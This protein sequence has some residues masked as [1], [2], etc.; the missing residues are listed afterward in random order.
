MKASIPEVK[1]DKLIRSYE[2]LALDAFGVLVDE[3]GAKEGAAR[4]IDHLNRSGKPYWIVTNGS[5]REPAQMAIYYQSLGL[6][7]PASRVITSGCLLMDYF[8]EESLKGAR[9]ACLG[10]TGSMKMVENAGGVVIDP[11]KNDDFD[12]LVISNQTEFPFLETIDAVISSVIK[13]R[14]RGKVVRLVLTNP[15]LI[16]PKG[17]ESFGITSGAIAILVER[18]LDVRF[19]GAKENLFTRLGKPYAPIFRMLCEVAQTH[20]IAMIGDQLDT[21]I[22]GA[23]SYG[24][25]AVLYTKGVTKIDTLGLEIKSRPNFLLHSLWDDGD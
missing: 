2:A 6:D 25:D 12:V 9:V 24:I 10:T 14:D 5:S 20:N 7:V 19:P 22:Q 23:L 8:K 17:K 21:D 1:I 13:Q 15:D 16:Y 3:S 4:L 11:L 18:V